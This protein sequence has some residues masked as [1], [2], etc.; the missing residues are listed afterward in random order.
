[1]KGIAARELR[2]L[3]IDDQRPEDRAEQRAAPA[4]RRPDDEF[5]AEDEA[6]QFRGHDHRV[7]CIEVAGD[8]G[9]GGAD[10]IDEDLQP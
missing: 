6:C 8:G 7:A 2:A 5:G 9:N 4:E 10:E 1:M 3:V